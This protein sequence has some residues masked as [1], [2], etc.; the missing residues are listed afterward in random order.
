MAIIA[1]NLFF[2]V[3]ENP[4]VLPELV[5]A[6]ATKALPLLRHV[7][8]EGLHAQDASG[9]VGAHVYLFVINGARALRAVHGFKHFNFC[10]FF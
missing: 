1:R 2:L 5:L 3:T 4:F 7:P 6:I 8:V 9:S 10:S